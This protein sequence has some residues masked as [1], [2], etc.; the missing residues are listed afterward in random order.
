ME[1]QRL[2]GG[3]QEEPAP[4]PKS[5][6]VST[7]EFQQMILR[8]QAENTWERHHHGQKQGRSIHSTKPVVCLPRAWLRA[9]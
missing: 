5:A 7:W 2:A 8:G 1:A 9:R 3:R 4:Q 6:G